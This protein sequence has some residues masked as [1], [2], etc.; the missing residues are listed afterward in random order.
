MSTVNAQQFVHYKPV[1]LVGIVMISVGMLLNITANDVDMEI[2]SMFLAYGGAAAL[3][4]GAVM[5]LTSGYNNGGFFVILLVMLCCVGLG[6]YFAE[7]P[8]NSYEP[9][10]ENRMAID[11][12]GAEDNL[13]CMPL[14]PKSPDSVIICVPET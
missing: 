10:Q 3:V 14:D 11:D 9:V 8:G 4:L 12:I 5:N 2:N 6:M 7:K 13:K 1:F